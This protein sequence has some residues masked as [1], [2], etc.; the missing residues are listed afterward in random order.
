MQVRAVPIWAPKGGSAD[1]EYEDA[2]CP[3]RA[4]YETR[5]YFRF[6]VA[7]GA[8][9]TS[10][11]G[12]WARQ[13]VRYFCK[14][15]SNAHFDGDSFRY[16]Q[17]R[18]SEIVR[19]RPL[20]WYAEQKISLGAFAAILGLILCDEACADESGH[21][22]Q[23]VAIGDSCLVLVRGEEVVARFPLTDTAAFSHR[24]HLLSSNP[25]YNSRIVDH[26]RTIEGTWQPGDTFYLM[27]DALAFWFMRELEE[28]Q[29]PWRT[30]RDFET[31]DNMERFRQWVRRLRADRAI[32][33]DDVTLLRV[34]IKPGE[35]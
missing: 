7:D 26:R 19:R 16:L 25:V 33:N 20:P 18:W 2:F 27:T 15:S 31:Q 29:T 12:I 13:L 1:S 9:E 32:R 8:T 5:S 24:P 22:W 14:D 35:S 21:S 23:A 10:Y 11:S 30:L 17:Q 28:G 4:R 3:S 34:D 6:A